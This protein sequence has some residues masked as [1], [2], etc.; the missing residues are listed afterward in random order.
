MNYKNGIEKIMLLAKVAIV[1]FFLVLLF[2]ATL[3]ILHFNPSLLESSTNQLT[4][5]PEATIPL[6]KAPDMSSLPDNEEGKE[7]QY[8]HD[9]IERT[10]NFIGPLGTVS[11]K[12]N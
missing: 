5:K 8:G 6:W 12:A 9:L 2:G 4:I 7:I 11:L 1:L 10:S 3:L